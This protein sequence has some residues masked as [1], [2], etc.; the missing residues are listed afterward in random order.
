MFSSVAILDEDVV[1]VRV[2]YYKVSILEIGFFDLRI[3][4][5]EIIR[6]LKL[7]VLK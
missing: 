4:K 7:K 2:I 5:E 6:K 3:L 1:I